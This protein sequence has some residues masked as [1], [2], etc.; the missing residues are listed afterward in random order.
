MDVKF[1]RAPILAYFSAEDDWYSS[2]AEAAATNLSTSGSLWL[3]PVA[4]TTQLQENGLTIV[5]P[6]ISNAL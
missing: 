5:T 2:M 6:T 4:P 3:S 1:C